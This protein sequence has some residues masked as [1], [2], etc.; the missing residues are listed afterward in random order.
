[1]SLKREA[2]IPDLDPRTHDWSDLQSESAAEWSRISSTTSYG[3][4]GIM[5]SLISTRREI[6]SLSRDSNPFKDRVVSGVDER[7]ALFGARTVKRRGSIQRK[8]YLGSC[9]TTMADGDLFI[10]K[11]RPRSRLPIRIGKTTRSGGAKH[12]NT[13][14]A[15]A[16]NSVGGW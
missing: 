12:V 11:P 4:L 10:N 1:M 2:W 16:T 3:I 6:A 5:V 14:A 15:V 9:N 13:R 8:C 7:W